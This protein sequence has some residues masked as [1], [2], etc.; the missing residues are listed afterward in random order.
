MTSCP[1]ASSQR[2]LLEAPESLCPLCWTAEA[3]CLRRTLILNTQRPCQAVLHQ[4]Q[5]CLC[6]SLRSLHRCG[7][8]S[9][10]KTLTVHSVYVVAS[11]YFTYFSVARLCGTQK[12]SVG[13][14]LEKIGA[15]DLIN[16]QAPCAHGSALTSTQRWPFL[17]RRS[18]CHRGPRIVMRPFTVRG[19]WRRELHSLGCSLR[20][21]AALLLLCKARQ[22]VRPKTRQICAVNRG[23]RIGALGRVI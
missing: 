2:G 9:V 6:F 18:G 8:L 4:W 17:G 19:C 5:L 15:A 14:Q 16:V 7:L 23:P 10:R 13:K 22:T 12:T 1:W 3:S 11:F 20:S 21:R